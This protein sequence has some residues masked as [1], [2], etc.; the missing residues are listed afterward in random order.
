MAATYATA[1]KLPMVV[2]GKSKSS[3]YF[4]KVKKLPYRYRRQA[5]SWMTTE[6]FDEWLRELDN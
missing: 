3:I 2:L 6:L 1:D 4:T 5:K